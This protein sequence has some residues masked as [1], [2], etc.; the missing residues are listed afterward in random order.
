MHT[1]IQN[2]ITKTAEI[3]YTSVDVNNWEKIRL[4]FKVISMFAELEAVYFQNNREIS[5]DPEAAAKNDEDVSK[6]LLKLRRHMYELNPEKG[7]WYTMVI[8]IDSSGKFKI[9]YDY[10]TKPDFTYEPS[11][12]KY[13]SE[14]KE[15]PRS[16]EMTPQW[17]KDIV[18][19]KR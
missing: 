19:A 7:A 14:V 5:F 15:F 1:E 11:K 9:N 13:I 17:L 10:K 8:E 16:D 18:D 6:F 4:E 2:L 3:A 12:E